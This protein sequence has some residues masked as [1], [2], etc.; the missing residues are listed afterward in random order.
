MY[1]GTG[2]SYLYPHRNKR[3]RSAV[4]KPRR[5]PAGRPTLQFRQIDWRGRKGVLVHNPTMRRDSSAGM[6]ASIS[7]FERRRRAGQVAVCRIKHELRRL[8][9]LFGKLRL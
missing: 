7:L 5:Y 3:C 2:N 9:K 4:N 1:F 8:L 6:P